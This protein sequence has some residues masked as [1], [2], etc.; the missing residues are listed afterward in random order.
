MSALSPPVSP[1]PQYLL[2]N[3]SEINKK[4]FHHF[5]DGPNRLYAAF[6]PRVAT[7]QVLGH[8]TDCRSSV[9]GG[10]VYYQFGDTFCKNLEDEFVGL[11]SNTMAVLTTTKGPLYSKYEDIAPNGLVDQF[12]PFN[13]QDLKFNSEHEAEKKRIAIWSFGGIVEVSPGTGVLWYERNEVVG[14]FKKGGCVPIAVP[15]LLAS[16]LKRDR[17]PDEIHWG[18]FSALLDDD[19]YIYLYGN[20][21]F[22]IYIGRV[23]A[24]H[25]EA[26]GA[27]ARSAYEY[28]DGE[29]FGKD[30]S[31]VKPIMSGYA[32][33]GV[34][35][36][37]LFHPSRNA[38]Y[39]FVGCNNFADSKII[40]G[41]AST[42]QGPWEFTHIADA[43]DVG[44]PKGYKYTMYPHTWAFEES[45]GELMVTWSEHWPGGVVAAKLVFEMEDKSCLPANKDASSKYSAVYFINDLPVD[46]RQY[47]S[48]LQGVIKKLVGSSL[49]IEQ[50]GVLYPA[51]AEPMQ[52]QPQKLHLVVESV[53]EKAVEDAI[54]FLDRTISK[55]QKARADRIVAQKANLK[56]ACLRARFLA[57]GRSMVEVFSRKEG[58]EEPEL[59]T[60]STIPY[61]RYVKDGSIEVGL[62]P[63]MTKP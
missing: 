45:Q 19:G 5:V 8:L 33:G 48:T 52:W 12:I 6:P 9:F 44:G 14:I 4:V 62:A 22:E 54:E 21:N 35:K 11:V 18:A 50:R 41:W 46:I 25:P 49:N 13:L 2:R 38:N 20:L 34:F 15:A 36:S 17:R 59:V 28:F 53:N 24:R 31:R 55:R 26:K 42:P 10:L 60:P 29:K 16:R 57:W 61:T 47:V 63:A 30:L 3:P 51:Q 27:Y 39:L 58:E 1:K 37:R 56:S 32:Q 23:R 43:V 40:M 7:T